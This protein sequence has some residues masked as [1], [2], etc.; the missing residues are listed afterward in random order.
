MNKLWA[1]I[2]AT[3]L[4]CSSCQIGAPLED[5][6]YNVRLTFYYSNYAGAN[7]LRDYVTSM[8]DYLYDAQ[9]RLVSVMTRARA[10]VLTRT[11]QLPPGDYTL[12]SWGNLAGKTTV[13][14]LPLQ[15]MLW[16]AMGLR[17]A[18]PAMPPPAAQYN[19]ERLHYARVEF[20][21]PASGVVRRTVYAGHAY[22]NLK[23]TVAGLPG[24]RGQDYVMRLDGTHPGYGFAHYN[25]V[26]T[27]GFTMYVPRLH[28]EETVPHLVSGCRGNGYGEVS[29]EF[30][31]ARLTGETIPV[32]SLWQGDKQVLRDVDLKTF[33]DTMLI[34]MDNNECQNFEIRV[35]VDG[36]RVY[37]QFVT[38]GDWI[39]GGSFG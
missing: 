4:L 1:V 29:G 9:G 14:P 31:A 10:Q 23:V 30:V 25:T 15:G 19:G 5:C 16:S 37:I 35:T 33:F 32:F 20:S 38:L 21:V 3:L 36:S 18:A 22:L 27:Q 6:D 39:D 17:Q 8:T 13:T 28:R 26:G 34:D 11:A 2:I 24:A 7:Q 12:V